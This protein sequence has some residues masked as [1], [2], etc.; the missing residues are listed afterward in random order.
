MS[1]DC[2]LRCN[3]LIKKAQMLTMPRSSQD[4]INKEQMLQIARFARND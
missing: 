1:D 4:L 2:R 3:A